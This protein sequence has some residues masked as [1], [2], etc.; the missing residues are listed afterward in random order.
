MTAEQQRAEAVY[1]KTEA[2]A[3]AAEYGWDTTDLAEILI[4]YIV[5]NDDGQNLVSWLRRGVA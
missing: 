5:E 4:D 2:A 3:M 1:V